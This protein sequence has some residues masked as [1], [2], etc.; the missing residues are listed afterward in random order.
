MISK[1]TQNLV[2]R[3]KAKKALSDRGI[4]HLNTEGY[5]N[6]VTEEAKKFDFEI[7]SKE[8]IIAHLDDE[9]TVRLE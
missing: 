3:W 7:D 5:Y 4:T 9:D 6:L 8:D 1:I 2:K